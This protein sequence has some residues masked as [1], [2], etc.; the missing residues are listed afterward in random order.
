MSFN[1]D[2]FKLYK[3]IVDHPTA[4]YRKLLNE[5]KLRNIIDLGNIYNIQNTIYN[6]EKITIGNNININGT[7][8]CNNLSSLNIITNNITLTNNISTNNIIIENITINNLLTTDISCININTDTLLTNTINC[9]E[10]L[11]TSN[12]NI[13]N[14][15]T[16]N[17]ILFYDNLTIS[18]N[19]TTQGSLDI[20]QNVSCSS[21]NFINSVIGNVSSSTMIANT[22]FC[23]FLFNQ[24]DLLYTN[25]VIH[26]DISVGNNM[27]YSGDF[28]I[29]NDLFTNTLD[30][31]NNLNSGNIRST[32]IHVKK[33]I[34][35]Y[36][37][38]YPNNVEA[39]AGGVPFNGLYRTGD[40]L[41]VCVDT[42]APVV[43]LLGNSLSYSYIN[44]KYVDLGISK[45]K[46]SNT[47]IS[48]TIDKFSLGTYL[49]DYY[50]V[51]S[52]NNRSNTVNR[53]VD[54]V[55]HPVI[56]NI[57]FSSNTISFNT[58]G[59]FETLEYYIDK[60]SSNIV[61]LTTVVGN[62]IDV[63]ALTLDATPYYVYLLFKQENNLIKKVLFGLTS[64]YNID[65]VLEINMNTPFI[66]DIDD[67]FNLRNTVSSYSL[68]S[69]SINVTIE[70]KD[71]DT[72]SITLTSDSF[73]P[74]ISKTYNIKY[75]STSSN[76]VSIEDTIPANIEDTTDPVITLLGDTIVNLTVGSNYVESGY[77]INDNTTASLSSITG[78]VNTD[79]V[80]TY[81]LV[82]TAI[83]NS[84][85]TSSAVRT[86]NVN[87]I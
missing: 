13:L 67:T 35:C 4:D 65:P 36:V 6:E 25:G 37:D 61:A 71:N 40:L 1:N 29:E 76:G 82:Y 21:I 87:N 51:D 38:E 20:L 18:S 55:N 23:N 22:G 15:V 84:N 28:T 5:Y 72:N 75:I 78:F 74:D 46:T 7:M 31:S 8:N 16:S 53:Q 77:T 49:I 42:N 2:P 64:S 62:N 41:N 70:V 63:S 68:P 52:F 48:G 26:G 86:I 19:I 10:T 17:N 58:S 9:N 12:I 57:A 83:D 56:S 59:Q 44:N 30:I 73:T 47:V 81:Y 80:G 69:T 85:N 39:I 50:S 43:T 54:V 66:I 14:N 45:N 79:V 3:T 33:A 34:Y 27:N 32:N 60:N 24:N 11:N